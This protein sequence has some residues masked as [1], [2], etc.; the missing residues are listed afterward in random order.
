[1]NPTMT[2]TG[3]EAFMRMVRQCESNLVAAARRL[4]RGGEECAQELVQDALVRAYDAYRR[5][6]FRDG[7]APQPWFLRIM[8]NGFINEYRRKQK[9][10]A[11]IDVE[12][13]TAGGETGPAA[14]HAAAADTPGHALLSASFDEPLQRALDSLP[15]SLRLC[16]LLVDV[17]NVSYDEA[18]EALKIPVGTVRSRLSRARFKL[19]EM[20]HDYAQDRRLI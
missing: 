15:D 6:L 13:L 16:V 2:E 5:G 4:C 19:A 11:G 10:D 8:T 20:L 12:T 1:M 17:E 3:R 14:T 9:W 18:A 7:N